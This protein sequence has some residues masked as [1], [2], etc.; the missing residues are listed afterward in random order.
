[1]EDYLLLIV[2]MTGYKGEQL[3]KHIRSRFSRKNK[4]LR[5]LAQKLE[6]TDMKLTSYFSRHTVAMTSQGNQMPREVE[7]NREFI[8]TEGVKLKM[9]QDPDNPSKLRLVLNGVNI[10]EWFREKAQEVKQR[11]MPKRRG[12]MKI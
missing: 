9:E 6:I 5:T 10:L 8:A 2:S 12:G 3:Y 11:V 1:V 4:N 7:H